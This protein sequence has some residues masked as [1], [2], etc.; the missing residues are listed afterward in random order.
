MRRAECARLL[1]REWALSP[2]GAR[3][4]IETGA[5]RRTGGALE[6]GGARQRRSRSDGT[7]RGGSARCRSQH[8]LVHTGAR[9]ALR[10]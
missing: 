3:P 2:G 4:A 7:Q 6:L 8:R 9:L 1:C 5:A 10:Q